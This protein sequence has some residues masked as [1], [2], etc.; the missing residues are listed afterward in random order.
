MQLRDGPTSCGISQLEEISDRVIYFPLPRARARRE[1]Y[2]GVNIYNYIAKFARIARWKH[3]ALSLMSARARYCD[4]A[5]RN[6]GIAR[7]R[8]HPHLFISSRAR[9]HT[10]IIRLVVDV[11][12]SEAL[13][14]REARFVRPMF[15]N[16]I[17]I[18]ARFTVTFLA[19]T[20]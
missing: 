5:H 7:A 11:D 13:G 10:Y 6:C 20:T 4:R 8:A 12:K 16:G 2:F 14:E 9:A 19:P 17:G 18:S 1:C 15:S 3:A